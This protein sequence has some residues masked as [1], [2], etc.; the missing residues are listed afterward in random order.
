MLIGLHPMLQLFEEVV[1]RCMQAG[2][3][4]GEHLLVDGS[5]IQAQR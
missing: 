1:G 4:K 3:V 5:F 2:L